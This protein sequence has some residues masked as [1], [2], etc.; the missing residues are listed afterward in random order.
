MV[1]ITLEKCPLS[2]RGDLTKWLQEI[3]LGVYVGQVSA[4]VRDN[5]WERVCAE[6]KSGRATMVFSAQNE[7]HLDFRV[8][9]S[10]W[11]PVDYDGLKLMLRPNAT[12]PAAANGGTE[13]FSNASKFGMINGIRT[14][15]G[16][17]T[18]D[19][20]VV[21]DLE[22]TGL[23]PEKDEIIEIAALRVIGGHEN[24]RYQTLVMCEAELPVA[25]TNLTGLTNEDLQY[26]VEL[27]EALNGFL[28]FV[29]SSPMVMHNAN[30]D[31]SFIE[32]A[33]EFLDIDEMDNECID[34]LALAK[35]K[36]PVAGGYSLDE[37]AQYLGIET[38]ERHRAMSDCLTTMKVFERL[39]R[40]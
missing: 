35:K 2:L 28:L 34:T 18:I 38:T 27:E 9:N 20:Y 24:A 15:K 10:T 29:G 19:E 21:V 40:L 37:L 31:S 23:V 30:F 33:L 7:Q 13:G 4:R 22:T 11:M 36:L 6:S 39:M 8:H 25:V 26:G 17:E 5:L 14:R 3:S 1:V 12:M 16:A 32:A